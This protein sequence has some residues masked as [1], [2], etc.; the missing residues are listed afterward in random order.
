MLQQLPGNY[1]LNMSILSWLTAQV[2]KV[3]ITLFITKKFDL[4]RLVGS[5]GMPSSHSALVCGLATAVFIRHGFASFEFA[6][7]AVLALI[8][9]Y[10]AM[11]VRRAAGEQ[12]KTINKLVNWY[13]FHQQ[14]EEEDPP[15]LETDKML[16]EL[17]GHTPLEVFSGALLGIGLV[18]LVSI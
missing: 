2:I 7:A 16:K 1:Y 15:V 18:T 14:S 6:V 12:A 17:I 13:V 11:G 8:V 9:M 3:L 5:G 10:D 4:E